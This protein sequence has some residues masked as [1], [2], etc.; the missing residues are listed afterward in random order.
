MYNETVLPRESFRALK[1]ICV[2][3]EAL[4]EYE[5]SLRIRKRDL[6]CPNGWTSRGTLGLPTVEKIFRSREIC[7]HKADHWCGVSGEPSKP[8]LLRISFHT[9]MKNQLKNK[10]YRLMKN[11]SPDHK[12]TSFPSCGFS[13]DIPKQYES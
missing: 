9:K 6:S 4:I 3:H 11:Y 2:N 10:V 7:T 8:H 13:G 5:L 12:Q 1:N